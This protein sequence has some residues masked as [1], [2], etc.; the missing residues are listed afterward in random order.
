MHPAQQ[1]SQLIDLLGAQKIIPIVEIENRH[2][3]PDLAR[4]LVDAG[5]PVIEVV[6]RT[7]E[8]LPAI[9]VMAG[10]D[11]CQV[12]AGT[13]LTSDQLADALDAGAAFAVTPGTSP[14]MLDFARRSPI[15]VLPGAM[16]P[17]EILDLRDCGYDFVKLYPAG[18]AGG[19]D[20]IRA[21]AGPLP[22]IRLCP[23]GGIDER[24][25]LSYLDCPTVICVGGS[26]LTP[27][28]LIAGNDWSGIRERLD[29]A[30][31]VLSR[32]DPGQQ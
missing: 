23:T 12:G 21:I 17:S 25:L 19:P 9:E 5:F 31:S 7:E 24:T 30:R 32:P 4:L 28:Q 1:S 11:G 16:T 26:W 3:A 18:N 14:A 2:C 20:M 6:L 8:A 15:P 10:I 29:A 22:G 27:R 13:T